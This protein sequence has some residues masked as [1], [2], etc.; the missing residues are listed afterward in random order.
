MALCSTL[1]QVLVG[2]GS[3]V[4][5]STHAEPLNS[6]VVRGFGGTVVVAVVPVVDVVVVVVIVRAVEVVRTTAGVVV[7]VNA[8]SG[9]NPSPLFGTRR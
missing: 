4:V 9:A 5:V 1:V 7:V 6:V 2:V 8:P 3:V